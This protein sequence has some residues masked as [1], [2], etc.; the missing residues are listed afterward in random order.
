MKGDKVGNV[1][2]GERREEIGKRQKKK[3]KKKM[4]TKTGETEY[5]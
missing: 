3:K 4:G 1:K 5:T 2:E